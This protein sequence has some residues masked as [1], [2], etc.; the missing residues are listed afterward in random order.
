M[1]QAMRSTARSRSASTSRGADG[2]DGAGAASRPASSAA[3]AAASRRTWNRKAVF[4]RP[5]ASRATAA[6]SCGSIS[7][8]DRLPSYMSDGHGDPIGLSHIDLATGPMYSCQ[9]YGKWVEGSSEG[10]RQLYSRSVVHGVGLAEGQHA[11]F[12]TEQERYSVA[13]LGS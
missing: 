13:Q 1:S 7:Y 5:T 9:Y 8:S 11:M 4:R 2:A 6:T 12:Q 3:Q 10:S